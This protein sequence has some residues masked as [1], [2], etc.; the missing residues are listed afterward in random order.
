MLKNIFKKLDVAPENTGIFTTVNAGILP[1]A[2]GRK[3]S[4]LLLG[5]GLT[6]GSV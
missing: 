1:Y 3:N 6:L 5:S 2:I 4:T